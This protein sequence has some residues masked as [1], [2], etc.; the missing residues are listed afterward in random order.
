M[1]LPENA[2]QWDGRSLSRAL[3]HELEHVHRL[4]WATQFGA[5]VVCAAY[6][7]HPLVWMAWTRLCVE[8]ERACDDAALARGDRED[9]AAQLVNLAREM[10]SARLQPMLSMAGRGELSLRVGA[11][12]DSAQRRGRP[13]LRTLTLVLG[14]A[15]V[16]VL[17]VAPLRAVTGSAGSSADE[18]PG[19][20]ADVDQVVPGDGT[21][22]IRAA[23]AGRLDLV[24]MLLDAGADPNL[25]VRGDGNPLIMAAQAGHLAV[26]RLL[27]D[28]GADVNAMVPDDESAL[29]NASSQG[30]LDVVQ[31]LVE[32][33][34]SVNAGAWA[35][36]AFQGQDDEW[37]TPLRMA[38][39]HRHSR[40]V[41]YLIAHGA[42]D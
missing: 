35:R 19:Q 23:R 25:A 31:L 14:A 24:Q 21:P 26:V 16:L 29:I 5:R 40:V 8:S 41:E 33:G 27:L 4:D 1:A 15:V 10:S 20:G 9:Y 34:A 22:L 36:R 30:H 37:R 11:V 38:R 39:T 42:I 17:G 6:W 2:T 28:R 18:W 7:F 32:R 13:G 12:L 3:V